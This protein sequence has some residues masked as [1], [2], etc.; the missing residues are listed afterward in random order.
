MGFIIQILKD[1]LTTLYQITGISLVVCVLFMFAWLY[2]REHGA[3]E[4]IRRWISMLKTN[5]EFRRFLLLAFYT[6]MIL[7]KTLFCR[8]IWNQ[9]FKNVIGVWGFYEDGKLYTENVENIMLF[10]PF[11][12]LLMWALQDRL[13]ESRTMTGRLYFRKA[14]LISF[15]SSVVI[16]MSQL[17][18]KVGAIQI[19][20]LVFNTLGGVIGAGVYWIL[21]R[22]RLKKTPETEK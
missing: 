2:C 12:A 19:S 18:L 7:N 17:F 4:G 20:D 13:W 11:L 14:L 9:P 3:K 21:Y 1:T 6:A 5:S 10:I 8:P 16:E 22:H 15:L